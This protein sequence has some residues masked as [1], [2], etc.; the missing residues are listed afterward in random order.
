MSNHLF[1]TKRQRYYCVYITGNGYQFTSRYQGVYAIS[2][3]YLSVGL[4]A[5]LHKNACWFHWKFRGKLDVAQVSGDNIVGKNPDQ[6][7]DRRQKWMIFYHCQIKQTFAARMRESFSAWGIQKRF[8][9]MW[10]NV[11]MNSYG[12]EKKIKHQCLTFKKW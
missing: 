7:V 12:V 5:E 6:H 11:W 1:Q 10:Q 9:Q 8:R 2:G 4:L 3:V